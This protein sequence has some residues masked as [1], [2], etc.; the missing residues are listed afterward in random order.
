[1]DKKVQKSEEEWKNQLTPEQ[2]YVT[3]QSGTEQA[4]T[5]QYYNHKNK[6]V[7][8]CICCGRPLFSSDHKFDS[9][10]GWPSFTAPTDSQS[11][12][13]HDDDSYGMHRI[14]VKCASCAAHLGHVFDDGPLPTGQR[15]CINSAALNFKEQS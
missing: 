11:I 1:M 9:G 15:Y 7:Y 6:G 5:G 2:Y 10:T 12:E 3:R 8:H 14:E 4:F 13:T